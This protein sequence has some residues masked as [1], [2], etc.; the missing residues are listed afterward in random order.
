[1]SILGNLK[2]QGVFR[3]FE[4]MCAIPHGSTNTKQISDWLMDFAR[5]RNLEAYQD[6]LN[7]VIIIK[8]ATAGYEEA[9]PVIL[10]GHMDMVCEKALDCQ[11]DMS[12]EG[13]DL[14]VDG[15][16]VYAKGTTLGGDDGI[17]VAMML[18]ILDDDE[19]CH[20]RVEAVF[21]VDEEIGM[22]GAIGID[23]SMLK[24]RRMLNLDSEE[25]GVFTV[26][27]AGGSTTQCTLPITRENFEGQTLKLTVGG[28]QGGHSGT[29]IDKG[30]GNAS[31]LLGR[32]LY[33]AS[34]R[35]TLRLIGVRGG[36]KDNAIPVEAFAMLVTSDAE[37]VRSV[38]KEMDEQLKNEYRITDPSVFV[39]AEE[40]IYSLPMD[41]ESTD[42]VLCFLTCLPNG[43]QA[44]SAGIPGLVQTSLNLG[45]LDTFE[46]RLVG[47][48]SV[49]SSVGSQKQMLIDRLTCLTE[50]LGGSVKV[51]GDYS[52][53]EYRQDS[54]LRDLLVEV[55][56]EQYGYEPKMEA[57]HAGLEC[58]IF[59]GKLPGLDC[60]SLGP[61]LTEAHTYREKLYI[62]SVQ[63]VWTMLLETLK[64]M[65]H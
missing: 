49:R 48:N 10:Q 46:A 30:L 7:N 8:E 24:G 62:A 4:E 5:Q 50:N 64:R 36:L 52:G 60:V 16:I 38:C 56:V 44:M 63:R 55:F 21:T 37:A 11:K 12:K 43:I 61:D 2:P 45:I 57:V 39:A 17:A 25:E 58:G 42:R 13:L 1:M 18:A 20:P 59:V 51:S 19:I 32:V 34:Q 40:G 31:L 54:P 27:C 6:P 41:Q 3:F 29:A 28:L 14:A 53:W 26:S 47:S 22:L 9:E 65:K 33:A 15:D 23:V 35:A